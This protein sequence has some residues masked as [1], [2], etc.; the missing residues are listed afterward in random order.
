[1]PEEILASETPK[2]NGKHNI[3]PIKIIIKPHIKG[4][5]VSVSFTEYTSHLAFNKKYTRHTE[6]Q[7]TKSEVIEKVPEQDS[8]MTGLLNDQT[9]NKTTMASMLRA[10]MA[11]VDNM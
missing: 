8:Y 3:T 4:I 5:F 2:A 9:R 10:L 6:R 7:N 1:M 11:K